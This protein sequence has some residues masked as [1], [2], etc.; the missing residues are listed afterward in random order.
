[1]SM[2]REALSPRDSRWAVA[3]GIELFADLD[4]PDRR[5]VGVVVAR[6]HPT[7]WFLSAHVRPEMDSASIEHFAE[8]ARVRAYLLLTQGPTARTWAPGLGDRWVAWLPAEYAE[9]AAAIP[10]AVPADWR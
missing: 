1:M 5:Q 2:L 6:P 4:E 3:G 7:G 10:D 9:A 8:F